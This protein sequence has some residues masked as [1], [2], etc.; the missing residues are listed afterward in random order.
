MRHLVDLTAGGGR[1][2]ASSDGFSISADEGSGRGM[3]PS[4]E[5]AIEAED[6][7]PTGTARLP[8][9]RRRKVQVDSTKP[10]ITC[11]W[12]IIGS[13]SPTVD[14]GPVFSPTL[15]VGQKLGTPSSFICLWWGRPLTQPVRWGAI[16][17]QKGAD[18]GLGGAGRRGGS[19]R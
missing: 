5:G 2:P 16:L 7:S 10:V 17:T 15:H 13:E 9:G 18:C 11:A 6:P 1:S 3:S 12:H 19:Y 14:G 8:S 4:G